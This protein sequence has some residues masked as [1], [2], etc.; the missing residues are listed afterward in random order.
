[1]PTS[2]SIHLIRGGIVHKVLEDFYDLD[3]HD[4]DAQSY[5]Y[6][7]LRALQLFE[8][9]WRQHLP[10]L[11]SLDLTTAELKTFFDESAIMIQNWFKRLKN[12]MEARINK[13]ESFVQSYESLKPKREEQ[14]KSEEYQVRGYVDVIHEMDDKVVIIDYK[15]SKKDVVTNEY[16]IQL[17][18][19]AMLYEEKYGKKPDYVGIDFLKSVERIIP[20]DQELIKE[21]QFVIEQHHASTDSDDISDYPMNPTPLCKWRT[22][23]CNFYSLC[24]EGVSEKDFKT[25]K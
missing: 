8:R 7:H 1:M 11:R 21:A 6:L 5:R 22:G 20:V 14:L 24:F 23:Q 3:I 13:G 4:P 9:Y 2:T 12:K 25:H 19:Y 10:Q 17:A 18:I 15:T 16:R